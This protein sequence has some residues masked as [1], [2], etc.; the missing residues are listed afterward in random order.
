MT[1]YI[2]MYF[3]VNLAADLVILYTTSV[4]LGIKIK[5]LR[6][7][8]TSFSAALYS[9]AAFFCT[10][11]SNK[12]VAGVFSGVII[13]ALFGKCRRGEFLKRMFAFFSVCIITSGICSFFAKKSGLMVVYT[14]VIFFPA[15]D[16]VFF[17]AL[18]A[19]FVTTK[20][21]KHNFK[22]QKLYHRIYLK[23]GTKKINTTA[24]YDTGNRLTDPK[25]RLPV[26]I[27]TQKIADELSE[28]VFIP[29]EFTTVSD[30][31]TLMSIPIDEVYFYDE[32]TSVKNVLGG[33]MLPDDKEFK[34]LLNTKV[35]P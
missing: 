11:L 2:D 27:I 29:L 20:I 7:F 6:L 8:I 14:D 26:I 24:Y 25:S 23:S 22:K 13:F 33:I 35:H 21:L 32:N 19:V 1:I 34:V 5:K 15:D 3:F 4:L 16:L 30:R 18:T 17:I 10:V 12:I 28:D 31:H 9:V